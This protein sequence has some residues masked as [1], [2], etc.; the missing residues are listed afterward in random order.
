MDDKVQVQYFHLVQANSS[1]LWVNLR[2]DA[3]EDKTINVS[4]HTMIVVK[5]HADLNLQ[6]SDQMVIRAL[7]DE[8]RG[9]AL[10]Q[11]EDLVHV[12]SRSDLDLI[13]PSGASV[14]VERVSGDANLRQLSGHIQVQ[15]V[16]GDLSIHDIAT[17]EIMSVGG[18]C[19]IMRSQGV[20]SIQ[21]IGSEFNGMELTGPIKLEGVGGDA[22]VHM[23]GGDAQIRAGGDIN[24][25]IAEMNDQSVRLDAGGD[26]LLR[27]PS[28]ANVTLDLRSR[29]HNIAVEMA[30]ESQSIEKRLA[31]LT[32]GSGSSKISID[33]GGDIQV[34]DDSSEMNDFDDLRED[35]EKHWQEVEESRSEPAKDTEDAFAFRADVFSDHINRHVDNVMRQADS[36]IQQAMKKLE[37]RTRR[38]ERHGFHKVPPIPPVPPVPG[39][40]TGNAPGAVTK[41]QNA[42]EEEKLLILKMLQEKKIT[43]EEAEKLLDALEG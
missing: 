9:A 25:S 43:A 34:S 29:G 40:W 39:R 7:T 14:V 26:V 22:N 16:G 23:I 41:K 31:S 42:S 30:G 6:G 4:D 15:R 5:T 3:M 2:S 11:D 38:L 13:V 10:T 33:A 12:Q 27:L 8:P 24:F 20:L 35:I 1:P 36:R 17:A 28:D 18:D 19:N 37:E 21:R 32:F